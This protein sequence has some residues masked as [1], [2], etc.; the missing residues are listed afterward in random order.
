MSKSVSEPVTQTTQAKHTPTPSI[1]GKEANVSEAVTESV[2]RP[3]QSPLPTPTPSCSV[4]LPQTDMMSQQSPLSASLLVSSFSQ[5]SSVP[6]TEGLLPP[7][8]MGQVELGQ[9]NAATPGDQQAQPDTSKVPEDNL[10]RKSSSSSV[11]PLDTRK[12]RKTERDLKSKD[13][14]SSC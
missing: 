2:G 10:K 7:L 1:L 11:R 9:T 4:T 6:K 14:S 3:T 8:T 12:T 13:R 5:P